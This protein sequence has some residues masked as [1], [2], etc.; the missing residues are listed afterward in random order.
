MYLPTSESL[1]T[2][3]LPKWFDDAKFGIFSHWTVSSV[4]SFGTT[5]LDPFALA[6]EEGERAAFAKTPYAEWYQ[7][8]IAIAE[9][10]AAEYHSTL[11]GS[12]DYGTFVDTFF[13]LAQ[14]WNVGAWQELL[15]RSGA[16]YCV[17]VTKHHDGALM[18]PSA[19]PNPVHGKRWQPERDLVGELAVA[20]RGA[21]LRFGTYYSGGLD[22]TFQGL[23][24][25]SIA[26]LFA[27]IPQDDRYC[28]YVDAHWRELI[29]RYRPDVMWHD[30]GHPRATDGAVQLIADYYNANPDG[31]VNDRYDIFGVMGGT[32]HADFTTPE[33]S[34]GTPQVGKKFEVCRGIGSSF[35]YMQ[36]ENESTYTS[37]PELVRMLVNIVADGGNLLLNI[38]AMPGGYIPWAQQIR[39]MAIGQWLATNGAA[40]YG[41][42]PHEQSRLTTDFGAEVRL[43]RG[44][45]GATYAM[46]C[47][48]PDSAVV[49]ITGLP[50][51]DVR[52]VHNGARVLR[53]G[54]RLTLPVR[55]D[56]T[57]VWVLRVE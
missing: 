56:D 42:R 47:G 28:A 33:Y 45:D 30:I 1:R 40:I 11:L 16:R 53:K 37:I 14:D 17:A 54:D 27:A 18:W 19:T 23:G 13:A 52:L 21:G 4:P 38:G 36:F 51:G 6:R 39:V 5:G 9:S 32:S 24:I 8:S 26:S 50:K 44:T 20:A 29:A 25:D 3:P 31:V 2:H 49:Q 22:W 7:N 46:V 34:S 10:P 43:T 48:R 15:R 57:P 35:G 12:P 41:S 55:P